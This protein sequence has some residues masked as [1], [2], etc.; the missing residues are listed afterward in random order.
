MG[1]RVVCMGTLFSMSY[2]MMEVMVFYS[3]LEGMNTMLELPQVMLLL[4][5][6]SIGGGLTM[7]PGSIG[8]LEG[9]LMG[10]LV[11][12]GIDKA[13]AGGAVLLHRFLCMWLPVMVGAMVLCTR[14]RK[15]LY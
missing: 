2:W 3:L 15:F 4:T 7:L 12:M 8:A 1:T 6:V 13:V 10:M 5:S 11:Y 14:Y 9:G